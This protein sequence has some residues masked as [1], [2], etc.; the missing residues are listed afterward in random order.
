MSQVASW[1]I[2]SGICFK[3]WWPMNESCTTVRPWLRST[4][5]VTVPMVASTERLARGH[6]VFR[7]S[8]LSQANNAAQNRL[9]QL[10]LQPVLA[11]TQMFY[12]LSGGNVLWSI[13]TNETLTPQGTRH[14]NLFCIP[15]NQSGVSQSLIMSD[16]SVLE[17]GHWGVEYRYTDDV[18]VQM[19]DVSHRCTCYCQSTSLK[20][21][22]MTCLCPIIST[23]CYCL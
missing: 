6:A 7:T 14:S 23:Y 19:T 10:I 9:S 20:E 17:P 2:P 4:V 16:V 11:R 12:L 8:C 18:S 22:G 13:T 1:I 3:S 15:Q 5:N 21:W